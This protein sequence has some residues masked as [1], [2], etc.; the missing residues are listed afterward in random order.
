ML[1]SAGDYRIACRG[2]ASGNGLD[3]TQSC[4]PWSV[5]SLLCMDDYPDDGV[6]DLVG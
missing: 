6:E 4:D 1:V 3:L 2:E 5:L